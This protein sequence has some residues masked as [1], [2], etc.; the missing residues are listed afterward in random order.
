M[1]PDTEEN[2]QQLFYDQ[3]WTDGLPIILPT[4]ERVK[5]MLAGTCAAP[6][7]IVGE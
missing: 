2:L 6:D 1:K 5:K 4:E 7:E 3:G